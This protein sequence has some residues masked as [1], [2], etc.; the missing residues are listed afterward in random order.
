ML[1][2]LGETGE[3]LHISVEDRNVFWRTSTVMG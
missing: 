2:A 3:E 1:L